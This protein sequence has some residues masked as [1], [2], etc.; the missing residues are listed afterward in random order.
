MALRPRLVAAPELQHLN[1]YQR[2]LHGLSIYCRHFRKMARVLQPYCSAATQAFGVISLRRDDTPP[3][4]NFLLLTEPP[5]QGL[6]LHFPPPV[7]TEAPFQGMA[8]QFP[9]PVL[10][11]APFQ[12]LALQFPSPV[13]T[14]PP[15][16]GLAL[17]FPSPVL[18]GPFSRAIE[19]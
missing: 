14:E 18:T 10:T 8:L 6:A 12:G 4:A 9:S 5:L 13:L 16:Q 19:I 3:T 11:E 2:R 15:F 17:H 1:I 7:L